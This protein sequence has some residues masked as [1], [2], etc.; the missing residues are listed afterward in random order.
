MLYNICLRN[1]SIV[2]III[3]IIIIIILHFSQVPSW[4][5][6]LY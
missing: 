5:M 1:I 2:I 6:P 3:I 4:N